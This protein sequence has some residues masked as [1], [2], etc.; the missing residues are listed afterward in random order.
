VIFLNR[1]SDLGAPYI[2]LDLARR[3]KK[4]A[5]HPPKSDAARRCANEDAV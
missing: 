5:R 2:T 1:T 4:I 3:G